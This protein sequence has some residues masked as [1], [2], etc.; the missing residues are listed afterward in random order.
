M[1]GVKVERSFQQHFLKIPG[2]RRRAVAAALSRP[3]V[4]IR[5]PASEIF[6]ERS[7]QRA[8]TAQAG[9]PFL[10]RIGTELRVS[11]NFPTRV[12]AVEA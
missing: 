10:D 12:L 11:E 5:P 8:A 6:G 2:A 4:V 1:S 9:E 3:S 7:G